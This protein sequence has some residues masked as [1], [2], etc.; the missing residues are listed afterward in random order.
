MID[1]GNKRHEQHIEHN[2]D[3]TAQCEYTQKA[4]FFVGFYVYN[5]NFGNFFANTLTTLK[6]KKGLDTEHNQQ[7]N[8]HGGP[9]FGW[10]QTEQLCL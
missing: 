9:C 7:V 10:N 8:S 3:N 2:K 4:D 1:D 6:K 5:F